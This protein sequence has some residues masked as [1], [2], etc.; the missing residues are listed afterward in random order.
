MKIHYFGWII[1]FQ[2]YNNHYF[3]ES[4][5][6]GLGLINEHTDDYHGF[7]NKTLI[8]YNKTSD[9]SNIPKPLIINGDSLTICYK[10]NV[11]LR[12]NKSDSYKY[13]WYNNGLAISGATNDSLF[14][15]VPGHYQVT[16]TSGC[17]NMVASK[18]VVVQYKNAFFIG[19]H[20]D[21]TIKCGDNLTLSPYILDP[22]SQK[23]INFYN[24]LVYAWIADSTLSATNIRNPVASPSNS[25]T[26]YLTVSDGVCED[27]ASFKITVNNPIIVDA[28]SDKTIICG[29][30]FQFDTPITYYPDTIPL[31]YSW[32]PETGLDSSNIASP[33]SNATTNT[34]YILTVKTETGCTGK[35][36]VQV[37]VNPLIATIVSENESVTCGSSVQLNVTTNYTGTD[38]LLYNWNPSTGLDAADISNPIANIKAPTDYVVEVN[39]PNGCVAKDTINLS[40]SVTDF[41][42]SICMVTVNVSGKNEIV[43]QSENNTAIDS[44]YFY[45]E[46]STLAG[47]Y[48]FIGKQ[49]WSSPSAFVD[50]TADAGLESGGYKVAVKDICGF[51]T[52]MSPEHKTIHL[53]T[54]E[55]TN[56]NESGNTRFLDWNE[57]I[58]VTGSNYKIYRGTTKNN[59]VQIGTSAGTNYNDET[60]PSGELFYQVELETSQSCSDLK[61]KSNKV[62]SLG[63]VGTDPESITDAFIYPNP[64][65]DKLIIKN[66][67]SSDAV[68]M[69]YDLQ[70]KMVINK[71]VDSGQIDTSGLPAG[72]YT[73]KLID[74]GNVLINKLVKE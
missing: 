42:P 66:V 62:S 13:Q 61:I 28:G 16:E 43:L 7:Y 12:A 64:A 55:L 53:T 67:H 3:K 69:I 40:T 20:N 8:G 22:D 54:I 63:N 52:E 38:T 68:I 58:G 44:A 2:S 15:S 72:M 70:G 36:T 29:D 14:V 18:T 60:A 41:L 34:S 33:H 30:H 57:Y 21:K 71:V 24:S 9:T 73:V 31:I 17:M 46:S 74:S 59:M 39:T 6:K 25:N 5:A 4:Y 1:P 45:R 49:S 10:S 47:V 27:N 51:L 23:E 19:T 56:E 37:I 48:E 35:D 11:I 26:Y 65:S 32:L 50:E